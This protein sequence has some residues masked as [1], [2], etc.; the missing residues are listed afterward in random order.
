MNA[1]VK[2]IEA[3]LKSPYGTKNYVD[4]IREIFPKVSMVSPDRFRKNLLIFHPILKVPFM[5][6]IIKRQTK[7]ISSLWQC[8]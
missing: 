4:L 2:K 8:S 1:V 5:W 6:E 7:R 3:I